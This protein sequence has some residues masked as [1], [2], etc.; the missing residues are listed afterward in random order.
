MHQ[1]TSQSDLYR[2]SHI[3]RNPLDFA[4]IFAGLLALTLLTVIVLWQF[5]HVDRIFTGTTIGGVPVGGMTRAEAVAKLSVELQGYPLV[6]VSVYA[7]ERQWPLTMSA[8]QP[9]FD[10]TDAANRAFLLGRQGGLTTRLSQQLSLALR[11][12]EITPPLTFD[13]AE[14]RYTVS[15]IAAD[16]RQPGRPQVNVNGLTV[17]AQPGVDVDEGAT[18]AAITTV[19]QNGAGGA[20]LRIPLATVEIPPPQLTM[21]GAAVDTLAAPPPK[22]LVLHDPR[23]GIEVALD[24]DVLRDVAFSTTPLRIDRDILRARLTGLAGELDVPARDARLRFNPTTGGLTV[25]QSSQPGR[26]LDVDATMAA[27]ET[28]LVEGRHAAELVMVETQ[29]RVDM[30]RVAEMGIRELVATG[31]TYFAGSSAARVRNIEVAAEKFDGVVIPPGEIFSFNEFVEDVSAAN[32]FEDSLIIWGDRTAVGVG[33]GVCQVSTTI[34]RAAYAAGL[35]IVE[36]YNH[37]YVVSWYGE[38]GMD[39]TIYTPTVDF[40]F[41][42]D[43]GAHLLVEPVV[44]GGQGVITFNLYGTRPDRQ[45]TIDDPV[46]TDIKTPEKPIYEVDESMATG[47]KEQVE[48]EQEGMTVTVTRTIVEDGTT[49]SDSITSVYQPWRAMYLIGPGTLAPQAEPGENEDD[50]G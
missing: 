6:P 42:N 23:T 38:P 13:E 30:N 50:Q 34:F 39:A 8:L 45:V 35:P 29:P 15:Q 40:R 1:A 24:P 2:Q 49:R 18:V 9:D 20:H 16:V 31:S 7:A 37:G 41:R 48:W 36:R 26:A 32:G 3:R 17:P 12:Y 28:A 25:I 10:V 43:T 22:P 19:L 44:N 14:L 27:V 21:G 4:A 47:E 5:W 46:V 11:G 33:G